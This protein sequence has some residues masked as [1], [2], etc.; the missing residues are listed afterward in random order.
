MTS[1][2]LAAFAAVVVSI[3]D[4]DTLRVRATPE[5]PPMT[6]RLACVDAPERNQLPWGAAAGPAL[7]ELLPVGSLVR[8]RPHAIDRYGRTVAEVFRGNRSAGLALVRHGY[9]FAYRDY[10]AGCSGQ[11]LRMEATARNQGLGVWSVLGGIQRP[12]DWRRLR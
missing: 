9:A 4:G 10:L 6:I 11:Y 7:R 3:G 8:V 1:L 12:W 2:P 5:S